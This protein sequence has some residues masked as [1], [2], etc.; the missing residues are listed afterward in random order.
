MSTTAGRSEYE[1]IFGGGVYWIARCRR[2]CARMVTHPNKT[3]GESAAHTA[4]A[5]ALFDTTTALGDL[6]HRICV[7]E[8]H[9]TGT[10]DLECHEHE[11]TAITLH[12][13]FAQKDLEQLLGHMSEA[14]KACCYIDEDIGEV[15]VTEAAEMV[16]A[17]IASVAECAEHYRKVY[18]Q[19]TVCIECEL[20]AN[21]WEPPGYCG[22]CE[23]ETGRLMKAPRYDV[24]TLGQ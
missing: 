15:V 8:D 9:E 18:H 5:Y 7:A 1:V 10:C 12:C 16:T 21:V 14:A 6:S 2:W 11:I 17:S 4:E 13:D 24:P 3:Q 22:R 20:P 23:K 19:I